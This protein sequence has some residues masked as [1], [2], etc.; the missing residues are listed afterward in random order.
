MRISMWRYHEED[1]EKCWRS[2]DILDISL[3][4]PIRHP[5]ISQKISSMYP[6]KISL[7]LLTKGYLGICWEILGYPKKSFGGEVPHGAYEF[8]LLK[9]TT[10]EHSSF[11]SLTLAG[12]H[13]K[14]SRIRDCAE[15]C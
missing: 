10:M 13:L 7:D 8:Q 2:M 12:R 1:K 15:A 5:D 3:G 11:Y 14:I 4:Y 9:N 6:K